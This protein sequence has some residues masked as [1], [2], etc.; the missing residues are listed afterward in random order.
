MSHASTICSDLQHRIAAYQARYGK[1]PD[2]LPVTLDE[3]AWLGEWCAYA[4]ALRKGSAPLLQVP[5]EFAGIRLHLHEMV[6][7]RPDGSLVVRL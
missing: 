3:W 4:E 2:K 1:L 5:R 6:F 7:E